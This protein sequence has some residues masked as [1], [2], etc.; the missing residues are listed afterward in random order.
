MEGNNWQKKGIVECP[1]DE[2]NT[3]PQKLICR[4][5]LRH[6]IAAEPLLY[7]FP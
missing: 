5:E 6:P 7:S 4:F 2:E 3:E 1:L